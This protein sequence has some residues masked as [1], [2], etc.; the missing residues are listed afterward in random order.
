MRA[1]NGVAR[2][3]RRKRILKQVEGMYG[4]RRLLLRTAVQSL[5]KAWEYSFSGR[6]RRKRDMRALWITRIS[7]ATRALGM[8]YSRL[9]AGL[10]KAEVHLDRKQLSELAL[11]DGA[12]FTAIVEKARAALA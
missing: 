12:A 8:T 3:K 11:R 6:K 5:H 2:R 10:K 1:T 7:A 9:I 4:R